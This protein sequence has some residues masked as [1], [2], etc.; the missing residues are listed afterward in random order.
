MSLLNRE[1]DGWAVLAR[2]SVYF[3][4]LVLSVTNPKPSGWCHYQ[5]ITGHFSTLFVISP[6]MRVLW[7]FFNFEAIWRASGQKSHK[8]LRAHL[9][10]RSE[11]VGHMCVVVEEHMKVLPSA[12][13]SQSFFT[14]ILISHFGRKIC[15]ALKN[16]LMRWVHCVFSLTFI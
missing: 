8:S 6:F 5:P 9:P 13:V 16:V 4:F 11:T 1:G 7:R 2:P 14:G 10:F 3:F 12:S 15:N